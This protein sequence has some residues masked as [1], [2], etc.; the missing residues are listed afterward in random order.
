MVTGASKL[1]W[2]AWLTALSDLDV[3]AVIHF[4]MDLLDTKNSLK[5]M[6][7]SYGQNWPIAFYPYYNQ[8]IDQQIDTDA[9]ESLMTLEDPIT[10]LNTEMDNRLDIDK[11]IINASGDDFYVP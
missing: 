6:Y 1:G 10:Y 8:D 11:Y 7:K 5:H 9:F 3:D 2:V 4:A